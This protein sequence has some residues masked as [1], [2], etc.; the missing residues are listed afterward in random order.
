M[1]TAIDCCNATGYELR[2]RS[3][4]HEGRGYAF[5]CDAAGRVDLDRMNEG[6]RNSY[7]FARGLIGRDYAAP[8][9]CCRGDLH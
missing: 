7:F 3:L 9:V 1:K 4:F 2:F 6:Q 5:A 8:V